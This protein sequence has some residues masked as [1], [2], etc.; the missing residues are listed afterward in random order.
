MRFEVVECDFVRRTLEVINQYDTLI[1]EDLPEDEQR[2]VTLLLNCLV[3]LLVLPFEHQKRIQ[4][5]PRF[6]KICKNDQTPVGILKQEWGLT[7]LKIERFQL[8]GTQIDPA[9]TTLRQ[10]V[11]MIRHSIAH[12]LF[13]DGTTRRKPD[14]IS[15]NY[16][17]FTTL[18]GQ[19]KSQITEISFV[20]QHRDTYFEATIPVEDLKAFA[21]KLASTVLIESDCREDK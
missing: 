4:S 11:A 2:E 15:V 5:A 18:D 6:P 14:G 7:R 13:G 8:D 3:G 12:A 9:Q 16:R 20:N 10:V 21:K 1:R 17:D 19:I